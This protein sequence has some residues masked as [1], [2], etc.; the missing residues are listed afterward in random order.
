M[1]ATTYQDYRN[2]FSKDHALSRRFQ[3]IDIKEPSIQETVKILRGLKKRFESYHNIRYTDAALKAAAEL[4]KRY[5]SDRSLPDTA[6]DV[7][8]EV[9]AY[10]WIR[11]VSQRKKVINKRDIEEMVAKIARIPSH[12][13]FLHQIKKCYAV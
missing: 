7:I 9:G 5:I 1:G 11:P 13:A 10:Q 6:I 2:I 12:P 4:S 8:D 3:K